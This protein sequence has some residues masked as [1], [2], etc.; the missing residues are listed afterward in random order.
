MLRRGRAVDLDDLRGRTR[1]PL[2]DVG[3]K[4][5]LQLEGL[6]R[7][8]CA[9]QR[10][11]RVQLADGRGSLGARRG[12]SGS[13]RL[14]GRN[15]LGH[16]RGGRR[17]RGLL[18]AGGLVLLVHVG[19]EG[20]AHARGRLPGRSVHHRQ[21]L[22]RY[23]RAALEVPHGARG[24]GANGEGA[25]GG[26]HDA[27]VG[28]LCLVVKE[29]GDLDLAILEEAAEA[30]PQGVEVPERHLA[31]G[32]LHLPNAF[33]HE[34]GHLRGA[35]DEPLQNVQMVVRD[36]DDLLGHHA[37]YE[38]VLEAHGHEVEE[39]VHG[40]LV[41]PHDGGVRKPVEDL[42]RGLD[43]VHLLRLEKLL[44]KTRVVHRAHHIVQHLLA[45]RV[46]DLLRLQTLLQDIDHLPPHVHDQYGH[47]HQLPRRHGAL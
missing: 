32:H 42:P 10:S 39:L 18:G 25:A 2:E 43:R 11:K 7:W 41:E 35:G 46:R 37:G 34:L 19:A 22:A 9:Y 12:A 4:E 40:G 20:C 8:R 36:V 3:P 27:P 31:V 5:V 23:L 38:L 14:S 45:L 1:L 13:S 17:W 33:V 24:L 44:H 29:E 26:D 15:S 47:R 21:S 6:R 30:L 16:G 28:V